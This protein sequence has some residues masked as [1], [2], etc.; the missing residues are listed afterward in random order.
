MN[1]MNI[2]KNMVVTVLILSTPS[3]RHL[4]LANT[5]NARFSRFEVLIVVFLA[6]I[7]GA[8]NRRHLGFSW[9]N[10]FKHYQIL[11]VI[12]NSYT[13]IFPIVRW[14][15]YVKVPAKQWVLTNIVVAVE[16]KVRVAFYLF[17]KRIWQSLLCLVVGNPIH[18]SDSIYCKNSFVNHLM[19]CH[20]VKK[21]MY[22]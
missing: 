11:L 3:S 18:F 19:F 13:Y 8:R 20:F 9:K 16:S 10:T 21:C 5:I 15:L 14:S 7:R 1:T 2:I 22:E 17:Q 12:P 4:Q 6:L